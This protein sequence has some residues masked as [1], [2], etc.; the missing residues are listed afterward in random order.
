MGLS[1]NL[2]LSYLGLLLGVSFLERREVVLTEAFWCFG[3][4]PLFDADGVLML[5]VLR[6]EGVGGDNDFFCLVF[7]SPSSES[8]R[9]RGG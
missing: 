3:V 5:G 2:C 1:E 7:S 8:S 4:V 6:L 9:G